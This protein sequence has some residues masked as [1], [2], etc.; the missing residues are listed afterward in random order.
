M[1]ISIAFA[2][3]CVTVSICY[4]GHLAIFV[5]GSMVVAGT[6]F[7]NNIMVFTQGRINLSKYWILDY[8]FNMTPNFEINYRELSLA[9]FLTVGGAYF[10]AKRFL[11]R[12]QFE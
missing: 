4:R 11:N 2:V 8:S 1:L 6:L 7:I 9:L 5:N 12:I 3:F 10:I